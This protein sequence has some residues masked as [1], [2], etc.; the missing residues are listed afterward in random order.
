MSSAAGRTYRRGSVGQRGEDANQRLGWFTSSKIAEWL[1]S[2]K[3]VVPALFLASV[4]VLLPRLW[5]HSTT[6]TE[7]VQAENSLQLTYSKDWREQMQL[8]LANLETGICRPTYATNV[9]GNRLSISWTSGKPELHGR[10]ERNDFPL[11]F[12]FTPT[13]EKP[14]CAPHDRDAAEDLLNPS[15]K[16]LLR[17][18]ETQDGSELL[19][20]AGDDTKDAPD[21]EAGQ[22]LQ[23]LK[24]MAEAEVSRILKSR[25]TIREILGAGKQRDQH[26]EF[27][28][29]ARLLHPDKKLVSG[30]DPR[31][32]LALRILYA[33]RRQM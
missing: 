7:L 19:D 5:Y 15:L 22:T 26:R 12:Q 21:A 3:A 9:K 31:A 24:F 30:E 6:G 14:Q 17:M 4:A 28:R 20:W 29:I 23:K 11:M 18:A 32:D 2:S 33:V 8:R 16:A 10:L 1:L 25:G 27:R 13:D